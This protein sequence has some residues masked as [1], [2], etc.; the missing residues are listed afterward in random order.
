MEHGDVDIDAAALVLHAQFE[1]VIGLRSELEIIEARCGRAARDRRRSTHRAGGRTGRARHRA[2]VQ[3][4]TV[5]VE[6]ARLIASRVAGVGQ[7][8]VGRLEA[9][10]RSARQLVLALVRHPIEQ[11]ARHRRNNAGQVL[12][13]G[14]DQVD[15]AA[16]EIIVGEVGDELLLLMRVAQ[17]RSELQPIGDR[18]DVVG[19]QGVIVASL[20][21]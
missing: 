6:P 14:C 8:P 1:C 13:P 17:P 15:R 18:E 4:R 20:V 2:T 7:D 3:R 11:M 12:E 5:E 10:D 19:E 16:D 9:D 21:V